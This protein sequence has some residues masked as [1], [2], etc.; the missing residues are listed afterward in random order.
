MLSKLYL[1]FKCIHIA[2]IFFSFPMIILFIFLCHSGMMKMVIASELEITN[3]VWTDSLSNPNNQQFIDLKAQ[4]ELDMDSAFCNES[5]SIIILNNN[6]TTKRCY[7]EVSSFTE[8]GS[9]NV[10]SRSMSGLS[11]SNGVN[12]QFDLHIIEAAD[13]LPLQDEMMAYMLGAINSTG[14]GNFSVDANSLVIS[15]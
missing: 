2:K 9:N 12:I 14:M 15:K 11:M 8:G 7:T 10:M 13:T 1:P 4:L 5:S 6:E 3:V